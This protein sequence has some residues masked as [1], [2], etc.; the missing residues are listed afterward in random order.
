MRI[1]KMKSQFSNKWKA[2]TQPRKQ[3][4]FRFNAPSNVKRKF[5]SVNLAKELREKHGARSVKLRKG[6][7]VKI[8]R[9][10]FRSKT[11]DVDRV[12]HANLKVYVVGIE[13]SKRDGSKA[14]VA[15]NPS[16]LQIIE[17]K[18]DD[19][20]RKNKFTAKKKAEEK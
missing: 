16:N 17:L 15:L 6:D 2:S 7:T 18:L 8:L 5:L 12:D 20:R 19:K 14:K 11:G 4:K 13:V 1:K 3:R 9:G 10:N